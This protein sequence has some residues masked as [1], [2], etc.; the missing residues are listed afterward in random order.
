MVNS[1]IAS[2]ALFLGRKTVKF[3]FFFFFFVY[4]NF[5]NNVTFDSGRNSNSDFINR[6]IYETE[7]TLKLEWRKK[8]KKEKRRI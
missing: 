4:G 2:E 3:F 8:K 1:K 7:M 5:Q 6:V